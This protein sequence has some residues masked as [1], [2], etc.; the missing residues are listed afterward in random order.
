MNLQDLYQKGNL[1]DIE[2]L[3]ARVTNYAWSEMTL[4]EQGEL[5]EKAYAEFNAKVSRI[6][7]LEKALKEISEFDCESRNGYIDEWEQAWAL[8]ECQKIARVAIA[9]AEGK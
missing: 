7:S 1:G 9:K 5:R 8:G 3:I 2:E 4:S 6:E